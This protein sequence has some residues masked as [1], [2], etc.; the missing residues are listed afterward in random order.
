MRNGSRTGSK[1]LMGQLSKAMDRS[2]DAMLHR[3]RPQQ[4][5]ERINMHNRQPP[6]GPR[7]D[8]NRNQRTP[9]N[10]RLSVAA[11]GG[12]PNGS[13]AGPLM[14]ASPQQQMALLAMLEE[15]ARMMSQIF[16]PQQQSFIQAMPQPAINPNFRPGNQVS[17]QQPDRSLFERVE[18]PGNRSDG[19]F[20]KRQQNTNPGFHSR[21]QHS[22]GT[23]VKNVTDV[24]DGDLTSSME[25]ESA[26]K[27]QQEPSS[28]T[29]C[30]FNLK[31][32]KQDCPFAH[33][34][35]AAPPGITLDL[36]SGCPFGARCQNRKCVMRHPSPSQN[37]A[38]GTTEDCRFFPN[39]TN[40]AC[41]FRHPTSTAPMPLCRF[42]ENC[43]RPGCKFKHNSVMC[44][45]NP[46][47]NPACPYKHADGQQ[48]GAFGDKVWTA[49]GDQEKEHVSER[50]FID[51]DMAE[52]LV[53]PSNN[54][55]HTSE[56]S[57]LGAEVVT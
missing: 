25:V 6:K 3:V 47:L 33:Q 5:T 17:N 55:A 29:I 37:P 43:T 53:V 44:K 2:G 19:N 42:G 50:K 32:S 56:P 9:S 23:N 51:D 26:Q 14:N 41:P 49:N 39:C 24:P 38:H 30:K 15:Q 45:F 4:G 57:S 8:L 11:N 10:P 12:P 1:R 54:L 35:P 22:N 40:P 16:S 34:S 7:G 27:S 28:D 46:C 20:N 48:K 36:S 52:E 13:M 31:C 21:N 18:R